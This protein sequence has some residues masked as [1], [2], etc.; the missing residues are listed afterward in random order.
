MGV[1]FG[2]YLIPCIMMLFLLFIIRNNYLFSKEQ[3]RL[4]TVAAIFNIVMMFATSI[5]YVISMDSGSDFWMVRRFTSFLN[6]AG[7]AFVPLLLFNIFHPE[8]KPLLFYLPFALS[9]LLCFV[10]MFTGVVFEIGTDNS[11]DRGMLF[12]VPF[13]ITLVYVALLV[14][15]PTSSHTKAK[16]IE[17][18]FVVCVMLMMLVSVWLEATYDFYFMSYSASSMSFA[19]YYLLQNINYFSKDPL[20]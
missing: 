17:R 13:L 2:A 18:I 5:D 19:M 9:V 4:F 8:K 16:R 12:L 1:A 15:W 7:G 6:F 14:V 3:N 11:Y 20:T 10:S